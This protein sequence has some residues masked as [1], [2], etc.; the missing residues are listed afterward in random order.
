MDIESTE[1][2]FH[3]Q[4]SSNE[5]SLLTQQL[6][7]ITERVRLQDSNTREYSIHLVREWH[8]Q[9]FTGVR[10]HAGRYRTTDYGEEFLTFGPNRSKSRNDVPNELSKHEQRGRELIGK[11][12]ELESQLI[13]VKFIEE[14]IRVALYLHAD[15]IRI[16]PFR[17]GNGRVG[18][19]IISYLLCRFHLPPVIFEI[20]KQEYLEC[21][22]YYYRTKELNPLFDLVLR[23]YKNQIDS[24]I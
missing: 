24:C 13:E 17:D 20:P 2:V 8:E 15:L 23:L 10:D 21:L 11:L 6:R 3:P 19:L 7:K 12:C 14:V 16:H 1:D 22:N 4:Y 18:R 5:K 9:L